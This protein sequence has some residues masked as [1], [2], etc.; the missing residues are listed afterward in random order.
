M[1]FGEFVEWKGHRSTSKL[2]SSPKSS[3]KLSSYC[4]ILGTPS[5][6]LITLRRNSAS[7]ALLSFRYFDH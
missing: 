4:G 3:I 7:P 2:S 5:V 1:G 6:D